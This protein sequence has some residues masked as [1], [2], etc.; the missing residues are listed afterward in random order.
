M[1]KEVIHRIFAVKKVYIYRKL[2]FMAK[3]I[4]DYTNWTAFTWKDKNI[5]KGNLQLIKHSK[6]S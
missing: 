4:Y 3:Y 6:Y 2:V 1:N 5:N